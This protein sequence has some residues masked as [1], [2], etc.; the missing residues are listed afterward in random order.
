MRREQDDKKKKAT[1]RFLP[2]TAQLQLCFCCSFI[3]LSTVSFSILTRLRRSSSD[4]FSQ[5][6]F[7][8]SRSSEVL[9]LHILLLALADDWALAG[10]GR[11]GWV[12]DVFDDGGDE[13]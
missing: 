11:G 7:I 4:R 9:V 2:Q 3:F 8:R 5:N 1:N 13:W 6:S 10:V 12:A